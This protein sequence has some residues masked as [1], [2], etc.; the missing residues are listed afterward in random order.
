VVINK[1]IFISYLALAFAAS[2][3]AQNITGI[4]EG[5]IIDQEGQP[6]QAVNIVANS[7]SLQGTQGTA[8]SGQGYF[9]LIALPPGEYNLRITHISYHNLKLDS[10]IVYLGKTTS[11]GNLKMISQTLETHD[12]IVRGKRS[13]LDLSSTSLETN[14]KSEE[15]E[16]LPLERNYR[17]IATLMPQADMSF[18]KDEVN[19]SG[20]TGWENRYFVDGIDVSDIHEGSIETNIPYNFV[21]EIQLISGGYEAEYKGSMGGLV[22][23]I[24]YSGGN[25]VQG[26]A[27]GFY[28]A[29]WLSSSPNVG[30]ADPA[31]GP[32]SN[33][34]AGFGIGGPIIKD[35][36][37]YYA[38]YNPTFKRRD[39]I[40][41]G[42][43]LTY[44]DKTVT[45][46]FAAKLTWKP[47]TQLNLVFTSTGDPT[48]RTAIGF[49]SEVF[50]SPPSALLN[51]DPYLSSR[52]TGGINLS[53][54]GTY[55]I[56]N[57][58]LFDAAI[59]R[60]N[61]DEIDEP[62][63]ERGR[64]EV[65]FYDTT[66]NW[67][68]GFSYNSSQKREVT[69]IKLNTTLFARNHILKAG[70]EYNDNLLNLDLGYAFL[71]PGS[72]PDPPYSIFG[73]TQKGIVHNRIP[74]FYIQDTWTIS[75]K[76]RLN[77]GIRWG[78]QFLVGSN[79]EVDQKIYGPF[80]PR[81]GF[82]FI[83]DEDGTQKIFASFGRFAQD[84]QTGIL[85]QQLLVQN[86]IYEID[87][88]S[89]PRPGNVSGDTASSGTFSPEIPDL[90][91]QY[92]DEFSLGYERSISSKIKV[93]VKGIY[94]ILREAIEE[95]W[96]QSEGPL[97][98]K[99]GNPGR[100]PLADFPKAQRDYT[101]LV[102]TIEKHNSET[103]NFEASYVLSRNYGNYPGVFDYLNTF[104]FANSSR[105]FD[106][107]ESLKNGTGLL[108]NDRT[109]SFKFIGSYNINESF[110][111]GLSFQWL[112]GTPLS[113]LARVTQPPEPF[114]LETRGTAGRTPSIWDLNARF[115]YK[116]PTGV[117]TKAHLIFD[118]FH[119]LSQRKP[120][121]FVEEEYFKIDQTLPN[122]NYGKAFSYQKP[123][124]VRLGM[125]VNF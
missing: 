102:L 70:V 28:T 31:D 49:I 56:G 114:F 104:S 40:L 62:F 55:T 42:L 84:L 5:R 46:S 107:V 12:I 80:Q 26:S 24:T 93:G 3:P 33:Y 20:G 39:V 100:G 97:V 25:E 67:S 69:G 17:E 7:T 29:N 22:N 82:V 4:I 48:E 61:R 94:R 23:V 111:A 27:F 125:E 88:N 63:T 108:P 66:N 86:F 85:A 106:D 64:N 99:Y 116:L 112:S 41:P 59:S 78:S 60:I 10:I 96:F 45:H 87:Y 83:P 89:D 72:S 38:A 35:K 54:S 121:Q 124:S 73:Q 98:Y 43:G 44:T 120:V 68:G 34:D 30:L 37:W 122:P 123:M 8:T 1:Y 13:L 118:I 15:F 117:L 2:S 65:M 57:Y 105:Q 32:F 92:Y 115:I 95:C 21:K 36:L 91:G 51:P 76:L 16:S 90:R 11:I 77:A 19:I 9:R 52:K 47:L 74:S 103:F 71:F 53:L 50:G 113:K 110:T 79:S 58:L 14:L 101:A 81:I 18:Y 75:Q 119:I 6:I 109:H